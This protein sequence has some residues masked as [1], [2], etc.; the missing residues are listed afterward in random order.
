[1]GYEWL[2][3]W[4]FC[5]DFW[6]QNLSLRR[7]QWHW[8]EPSPRESWRTPVGS[9]L[10]YG[11][12]EG[13]FVVADDTAMLLIQ[14]IF[15]SWGIPVHCR[16]DPPTAIYNPYR[17]VLIRSAWKPSLQLHGFGHTHNEALRSSTGKEGL[18]N[19]L[20]LLT[21]VQWV[22]T[23]VAYTWPSPGVE[24][25]IQSPQRPERSPTGL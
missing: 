5:E 9:L 16:P 12:V 21:H 11:S 6:G 17:H 24:L 8:W 13:N 2:S 19:R 4:G 3:K 7:Q 25:H 15:S 22:C 23:K 20:D 1:M 10:S 14:A 18:S